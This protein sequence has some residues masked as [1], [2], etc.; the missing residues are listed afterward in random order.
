MIGIEK[1]LKGRTRA[2]LLGKLLY[3]VHIRERITRPLQEQHRNRHLKKVFRALV[4][5]TP[6]GMQREPEEREPPDPG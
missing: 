2:E 1:Q 5:R 3:E 4:R 6:D